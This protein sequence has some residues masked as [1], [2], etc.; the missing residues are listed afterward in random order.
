MRVLLADD[1]QKVRY[2]LHVLLNSKPGL[3]VVSEATDAEELFYRLKD[4][5]PDLVIL[6]WLLPGLAEAGSIQSLRDNNPDLFVIA[7]SGRPEL[8]QAALD[9]GADDFV[10]KIDPPERLLAV[11][12]RC[13]D[14]LDQAQAETRIG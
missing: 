13:Q 8:G 10:S 14:R 1:Q 2:A 7:L 11:V 3:V 9:A 5:T 6:D 12:A 4:A